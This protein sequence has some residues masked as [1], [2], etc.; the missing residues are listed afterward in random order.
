MMQQLML[1][2]IS[3]LQI[4]I[5]NQRIERLIENKRL[6]NN[7]N[8]LIIIRNIIKKFHLISNLNQI[9]S[10]YLLINLI[11]YM[12]YSGLFILQLMIGEIEIQ[13]KIL[14]T[15]LTLI[16]LIVISSLMLFSSCVNTESKQTFKLLVKLFSIT[17]NMRSNPIIT[18]RNKL[19]VN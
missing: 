14:W 16:A 18:L 13:F 1:L 9:W 10:K 15:F 5:E 12:L 19:K 7:R 2:Q 3:K 17:I 8:L 4:S 11:F 6:I